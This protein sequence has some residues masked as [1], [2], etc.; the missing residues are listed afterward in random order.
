MEAESQSTD[1]TK[2]YTIGM[3]FAEHA[4]NSRK[5]RG[6]AFSGKCKRKCGSLSLS[7]L[8]NKAM[9]AFTLALTAFKHANT[10]TNF[11]F[12]VTNLADCLVKMLPPPAGP[13]SAFPRC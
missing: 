10:S 4:D 7:I 12:F 6:F 8:F 9:H 2:L 1:R 11:G 3:P 13:L 5:V